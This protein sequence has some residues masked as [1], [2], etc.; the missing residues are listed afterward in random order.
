MLPIIRTRFEYVNSKGKIARRKKKTKMDKQKETAANKFERKKK[1]KPHRFSQVFRLD[2]RR[3]S[4]LWSCWI[5]NRQ[6]LGLSDTSKPDVFIREI[7]IEKSRG[8]GE[9]N[10]LKTSEKFNWGDIYISRPMKVV[11]WNKMYI[12]GS[13]DVPL[14][15]ALSGGPL[16]SNRHYSSSLA[17]TL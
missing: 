8:A 4:D 11:Y 7:I 3:L 14:P 1:K 10:Y 12:L 6:S 16:N 13:V 2:L 17:V 15:G 5:F 9:Q